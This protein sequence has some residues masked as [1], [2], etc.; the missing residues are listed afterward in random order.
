MI[1]SSTASS[2]S[3]NSCV[4]HQ[5]PAPGAM[6]NNSS[7]NCSESPTKTKKTKKGALHPVPLAAPPPPPPPPPPPGHSAPKKL[8]IKPRLKEKKASSDDDVITVIP[9]EM[10]KRTFQ[11]VAATQTQSVSAEDLR[12]PTKRSPEMRTKKTQTPESALK[13][14]KRLEWDPSAD[15]GYYKRAVSTSNISTLERSVLESSNWRQ[16]CSDTDLTRDR[17]TSPMAPEKPT[18]PPLASSTF[19]NRSQRAVSAHPV[20][21][22]NQSSLKSAHTSR[23]DPNKQDSLCSSSRKEN[24]S[25]HISMPPP[26]SRANSRRESLMES[27]PSSRSSRILDSRLSSRRE[28]QATS[29]YGSSAASSFDYNNHPMAEEVWPAKAQQPL[30]EK[31]IPT[32]QQNREKRKAEKREKEKEKEREYT[33]AQLEK[34]RNK[35]NR[36]KENRQPVVNNSSASASSTA[37]SAPKG[38]LDLGIELLCSLVNSRSLSE[39]QKKKLMLDIAKKI[40]CLELPES[41]PVSQSHQTQTDNAPVPVAAPLQTQD[42]AMNT[43]QRYSR[44]SGSMS[45]RKSPVMY[46]EM[47]VPRNHQTQTD[48]G[49]WFLHFQ[50]VSHILFVSV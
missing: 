29:L 45:M 39:S 46:L 35:R 14:H 50:T 13:S 43:S 26:E 16:P 48:R 36:N 24:T 37:G 49:E 1:F 44:R 20:P 17:G 9:I 38:D 5:V 31:V 3:S 7:D 34:A 6:A 19:V 4:L 33:A 18:P 22:S 23:E 40:S 47:V 42:V 15:V 41:R 8:K 25:R 30:L 28:S 10:E 32:D 27:Q 11:T 2:G 21:I 12:T